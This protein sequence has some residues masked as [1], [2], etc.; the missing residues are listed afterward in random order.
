ML[1]DMT[2]KRKT[3]D[4]GREMG[5]RL[6]ELRQAAGLSQVKLAAKTGFALR[7]VQN[8]EYGKRTFDFESAI[9]LADALGVSLEVLAGREETKSKGK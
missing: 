2:R 3:T 1:S 8:W 6:K 9:K 7:T 5:A 4:W